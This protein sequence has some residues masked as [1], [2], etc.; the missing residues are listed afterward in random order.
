VQ[1]EIIKFDEFELDLGRYELRRSDG[2]AVKLEKIPMDLLILL[3]E[4][5][6]QLVSR[7]EIVER[8]WGGDVHVDT[9]QGVN[10]A[11]RKSVV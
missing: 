6:G 5:R 9:R 1:A 3:V 2:Q 7:E 11:D 10:T 8:L 4:K